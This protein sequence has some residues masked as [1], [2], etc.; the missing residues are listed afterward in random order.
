MPDRVGR[1]IFTV[2]EKVLCTRLVQ[3]SKLEQ[4]GTGSVLCVP[5]N[6]EIYKY[7]VLYEI[8]TT[9]HIRVL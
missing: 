7:T 2:N 9:T 3:Y 1:G 8:K 5:V 4:N 6:R